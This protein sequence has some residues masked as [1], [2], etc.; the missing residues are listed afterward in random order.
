[1]SPKIIKIEANRNQCQTRCNAFTLSIE[2]CFN[3]NPKCNPIHAVV[4]V[5]TVFIEAKIEFDVC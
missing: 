4:T 5:L 1:M 2:L 3:T